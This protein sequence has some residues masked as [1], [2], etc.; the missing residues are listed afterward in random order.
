MFDAYAQ[1]AK[2]HQ[3]AQK[4]Y[5]KFAVTASPHGDALD[6]Q[7]SNGGGYAYSNEY[8]R[9]EAL[10]KGDALDYM[11]ELIAALDAKGVKVFHT[12]AAMDEN[13]KDTI[14][15]DYI[16][17]TFEKVFKEKFQGIEMITDIKDAFVPSTQMKDSAW[18]LTREG[19]EART[20]VVID[21]LK[22]ALGK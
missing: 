17:N 4:A 2:S 15:Y 21:D 3:S 13:G 1:F 10:F 7:T 6:N 11:A 16:T 20:R 8:E 22:A 5:D 12:Y 18:H 9:R 19:A 14:D